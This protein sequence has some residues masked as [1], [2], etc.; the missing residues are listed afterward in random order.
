[1][2]E[3]SEDPDLIMELD[4]LVL[5]KQYYSISEVAAMFKVNTS[6]IRYWENEFDILQPKKNR[7][8][9]RL[10]RQEDIHH[11]KL[12]YH[13]LRERKYTIEGAKQKL[14]EDHKLAARNFE[15]VQALLKVRGFLTELKD[16]L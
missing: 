9:D 10:F 14:K 16:Q 4:K 5:D 8:G 3:L 2:K 11:L 13:L 6:L 15:M 7:K 12:I 1:M